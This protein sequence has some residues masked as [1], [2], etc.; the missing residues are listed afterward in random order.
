ML[1]ILILSYYELKE[2]LLCA[3]KELEKFGFIV[4]NF[5]LFQYYKDQNDK[6]EDYATL[7]LQSIEE[8]K[9]DVIIA[10]V[11]RH[12]H[13]SKALKIAKKLKCKVFLVTHA[14]FVPGD[15][16]RSFLSKIA[17][18]FYDKFIGPGKLKRF[19]KVIAF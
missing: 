17:V 9:P 6:R 10:H 11:Y 14:P 4:Q 5:P 13:T 16:T 19:D 15:T 18:R 12:I 3:S 1:K 7:C 2:S 8:Y